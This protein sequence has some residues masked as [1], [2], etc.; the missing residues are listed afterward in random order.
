MSIQ[1][2]NHTGILIKKAARLFEQAANKDLE[3]LGVTYAQTTFLIRLWEKDGQSQIELAKS[4]GLKQPTVVRTL[5]RME[6][7]ELITRVRNTEDRRIFNFFL[8]EKAKI[9][10]QKLE[11]QVHSMRH[12]S[13]TNFSENEI[14]L[15]NQLI[16]KMIGNLE[17]FLGT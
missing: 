12:L 10:C 3:Q 14:A 1:L 6:R 16:V 5:D 7:D 15:L 11:E 13:T 17:S 8:T 9:A 2:D 4:A